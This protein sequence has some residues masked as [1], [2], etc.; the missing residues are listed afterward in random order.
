MV[1]HLAPD[2]HT[3]WVT[4]TSA[5]CTSVFKPVWIDAGLPNFD[6]SPTGMYEGAT[7]WWRHENLHREI[8]RDYSTRIKMI[9]AERDGLEGKFLNEVEYCFE[10]SVEARQRLT[11]QCFEDVEKIEAQWLASVINHPIEQRR[12]LFDQ[13]AWQGFDRNAN[14]TSST[15]EK[16]AAYPHKRKRAQDLRRRD[17][18]I[19]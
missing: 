10:T 9:A 19:D 2:G 18:I 4:G 14:R 11:Q 15:Q 17:A 12:P 7:V 1:S 16:L 3:H 5:T 8:L 13:I 6:P